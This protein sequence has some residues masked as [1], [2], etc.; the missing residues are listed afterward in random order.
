[1]ECVKQK[2]KT[3][4]DGY[5]RWRRSV[6]AAPSGSKASKK[7]Y[8]YGEVMSFLNVNAELRDT[9]SSN[10]RP[11][12]HEDDE[13]DLE[14]DLSLQHDEL[15]N[16][17]SLEDGVRKL[18]D[19]TSSVMA[20]NDS[21]PEVTQ[22]LQKRKSP[23]SNKYKYNTKKSKPTKLETD[24]SE[25]FQLAK[26]RF[27][28]QPPTLD[29]DED[30]NF[31][32]SLLPTLRGLDVRQKLQFRMQVMT[33]LQSVLAAAS[34]SSAPT[35]SNY[36]YYNPSQQLPRNNMQQFPYS[37]QQQYPH[38]QNISYTRSPS[39][40]YVRCSPLMPPHTPA[41]NLSTPLPSPGSNT[42]SST[43]STNSNNCPSTILEYNFMGDNTLQQ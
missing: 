12:D 13:D 31:F 7:K 40:H 19:E 9:E 25:Y 39:P 22:N 27:N 28:V 23:S 16:D 11:D 43:H 26:S 14:D 15:L 35:H 17:L 6:K 3:L 4:R 36:S 33:A 38:L 18:A 37:P 20:E 8:C 10:E 21:I 5:T 32:K 41:S 24:M 1:M 34:T 2:W 29:E 42:N 30:L